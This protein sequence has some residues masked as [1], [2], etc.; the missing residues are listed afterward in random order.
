MVATHLWQ[1][2]LFLVPLFLTGLL[3][4]R[5]PARFLNRLYWLGLIKL[6]LPLSLLNGIGSRLIGCWMDQGAGGNEERFLTTIW[7]NTSSIL[8]PITVVTGNSSGIY[9]FVQGVG[10]YLSAFWFAG[11]TGLGVLWIL[12]IWR[13]RRRDTFESVSSD[14]LLQR[15]L[16]EAGCGKE[17]PL[18]SLQI[19][20]HAT[21][22]RVTGLLRP[23]IIIPKILIHKLT[24][25]ELRC[26]LLH[27][28]AHRLRMDPLRGLIQRIVVMVFFYYPLLWPLM[29]LLRTTR[30]M[31]CDEAAVEGGILPGFYGN[32]L[33]RAFSAGLR[34]AG[35][36]AAIPGGDRSLVSRR[37]RRLD[38]PWRFRNMARYRIIL[39]ACVALLVAG[40]IFPLSPPARA[41][42]AVK[43]NSTMPEV[44]H[45]VSPDYPEE[46]RKA[47]L[48]GKVILQVTIKKDGSLRDITVLEEVE[49]G[50][51]LTKASIKALEQWKFKPGTEDGEPVELTIAIPFQFR[52]DSEPKN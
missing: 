38:Q 25:L 40:S 30:E 7:H 51:I 4:R 19:D 8:N 10:V 42:S 32:A 12:E 3:L 31:A 23:K 41:E 6:F 35:E 52:L 17:I 43:E 33:A 28:N 27:E 50:E 18:N 36:F 49:E 16:L 1:T 9:H 15:R 20:E 21:M 13:G 26:I 48:E 46:A 44:V 37:L 47:G 29:S 24:P 34:T 45:Q 14:A 5:A 22:P 11:A 2:T 39:A